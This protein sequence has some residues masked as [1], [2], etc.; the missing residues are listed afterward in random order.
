M[1]I[2]VSRGGDVIAECVAFLVRSEMA[3]Y[4]LQGICSEC[5]CALPEDIAYCRICPNPLCVPCFLRWG[6]LCTHHCLS[7]YPTLPDQQELELDFDC[8]QESEEEASDVDL[9][10]ESEEEASD[11][12]LAQEPAEE[13]E[14]SAIEIDTSDWEAD[15]ASTD[16]PSD[17]AF[18][19]SPD[20]SHEEHEVGEADEGH[21]TSQDCTES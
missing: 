2:H 6:P 14:T 5:L 11:V 3:D 19:F 18:E 4:L 17:S 7:A 10:Q 15:F 20:E 16:M 8:G 21:E 12:D 1:I 9:A 13:E